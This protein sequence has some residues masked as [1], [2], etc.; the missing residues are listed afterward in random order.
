M[1]N[2]VPYSVQ[3]LFLSEF[4]VIL[5]LIQFKFYFNHQTNTVDK[6]LNPVWNKYG[7]FAVQKEGL[8][9]DCKLVIS[10]WD[11]DTVGTDDDLGEAVIPL[12]EF[13]DKG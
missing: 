7:E 13:R 11:E 9:E 3:I 1:S 12:K 8:L 10:V 5:Y 6:T 2:Y 4:S